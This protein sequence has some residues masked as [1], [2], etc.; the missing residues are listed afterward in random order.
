MPF[1]FCFGC[2][3]ATF[4]LVM[5]AEG[6]IMEATDLLIRGLYTDEGRL[7]DRAQ[8]MMCCPWVWS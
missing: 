1:G 5:I 7:D 8:G 6:W 4:V 3:I 2:L